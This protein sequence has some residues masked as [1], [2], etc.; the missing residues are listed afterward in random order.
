VEMLNLEYYSGCLQPLI[1]SM[2]SVLDDGLGLPQGTHMQFDLEGLTRMDT[3]SRFKTASESLKVASINEA[4][5][6][7]N[8]PPIDGGD[9][10]YLQ[11]Q[12]YSVEDLVKLRQMEF[13][14]MEN[15]QA[16]IDDPEN[17]LEAKN[18]I[19]RMRK[20]ILG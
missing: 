11:V 13:A 12:N 9:S 4:R 17:E 6:K 14:S 1:E 10:V 18:L 2:E 3:E 20:G 16:P 7:L 8:M 5:K 15:Q 19:D